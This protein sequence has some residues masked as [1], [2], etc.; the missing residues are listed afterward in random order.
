MESEL[1]I[2]HHNFET[3]KVQL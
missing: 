1:D 2:C 3:Q